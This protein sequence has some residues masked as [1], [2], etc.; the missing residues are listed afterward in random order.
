MGRSYRSNL[1]WG[2]SVG[3]TATLSVPTDE[4]ERLF[5]QTTRCEISGTPLP[6]EHRTEPTG[7]VANRVSRTYHV[8]HAPLPDRS[9]STNARY[10]NEKEL[11]DLEDNKVLFS[12]NKNPVRSTV[13]G[14]MTRSN[15]PLGAT[16]SYAQHFPLHSQEQREA[17]ISA[18]Q[19]P[20]PK[21]VIGCSGLPRTRSSTSHDEHRLRCFSGVPDVESERPNLAFRADYTNHSLKSQYQLDF[22]PC[23]A[24]SAPA[25]SRSKKKRS[26]GTTRGD[27]QHTLRGHTR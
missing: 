10:H 5:F 14:F 2:V 13:P 1:S 18:N 27:V 26:E 12:M 3:A 15:L 6:P 24:A 9:A 11:V 25:I 19:K 21:N 4:R 8:R 7:L 16:T 23:R 22:G 17:S 20:P